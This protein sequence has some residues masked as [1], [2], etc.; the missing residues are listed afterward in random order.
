MTFFATIWTVAIFCGP[1]GAHE[2]GIALGAQGIRLSNDVCQPLR[3]TPRMLPG[4]SYSLF[5]LAHEE[6]HERDPMLVENSGNVAY[7][8]RVS[9]YVGTCGWV[10][11]CEAF[12]DCF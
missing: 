12:A 4:T 3:E 2:S 11:P 10:G 7:D 9:D 8:Q 6:G 1:I 5:V